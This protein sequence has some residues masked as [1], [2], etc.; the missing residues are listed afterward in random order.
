MDKKLNK[1]IDATLT[2]SLANLLE[3]PYWKVE[4]NIM[5]LIDP[6]GFVVNPKKGKK[7]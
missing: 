3:K 1:L 7:E 2:E 5:Y 6:K 4:G